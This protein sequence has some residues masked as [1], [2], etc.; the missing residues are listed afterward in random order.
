MVDKFPVPYART[1]INFTSRSCLYSCTVRSGCA[2]NMSKTKAHGGGTYFMRRFKYA[3]AIKTKGYRFSG[4]AEYCREAVG[5]LQESISSSIKRLFFN[6]CISVSC[7]FDSS[8]S[9]K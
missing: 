4:L 6:V 8:S 3:F 5:C 1:K 2:A 7:S 9:N